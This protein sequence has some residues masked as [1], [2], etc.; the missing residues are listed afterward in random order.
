MDL[1]GITDENG[2]PVGLT[3]EEKSAFDFEII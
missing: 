2:E 1:T 3:D